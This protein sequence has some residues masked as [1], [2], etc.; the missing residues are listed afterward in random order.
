[1]AAPLLDADARV[2]SIPKPLQAETFIAQ[3]AIEGFVGRVL[4]RLSR[5]DQ[6]R[7]DG[8]VCTGSLE[9]LR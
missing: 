2:H 8:R 1:V 4:P 6:R 9:T 5:I 3:L 7:V